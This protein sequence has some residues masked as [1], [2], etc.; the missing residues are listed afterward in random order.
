MVQAEDPVVIVS[1]VCA[2]CAILHLLRVKSM[3]LGGPTA[4]ASFFRP[5]VCLMVCDGS[6]EFTGPRS[7]V[8][9]NVL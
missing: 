5:W 1:C 3:T 6:S 8:G 2:F 9:S 4:G 7:K